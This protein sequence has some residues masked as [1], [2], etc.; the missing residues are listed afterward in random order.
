MAAGFPN[1]HRGSS[2]G[3]GG[4]GGVAQ[5]RKPIS[6]RGLST[7]KVRSAQ[8]HWYIDEPFMYSVNGTKYYVHQNHLFSAMAQTLGTGEI[9]WRCSYDAFG[10]RNGDHAGNMARGWKGM[11][12]DL[13]TGLTYAR[14][15]Y[16]NSKNGLFIN[17]FPYSSAS[18]HFLSNY[19]TIVM[20]TSWKS[21]FWGSVFSSPYP[22]RRYSLYDAFVGDPANSLEPFSLVSGPTVTAYSGINDP[23]NSVAESFAM[24]G[25]W[26]EG[27]TQSALGTGL[28]HLPFDN[29][30]FPFLF[31]S[32][33][34]LDLEASYSGNMK[35]GQFCCKDKPTK[36]RVLM[37]AP[38]TDTK[39]NYSKKCCD[40][41]F[42]VIWSPDDPVFNQ[43]PWPFNWDLE[44]QSYWE[45]WGETYTSDNSGMPSGFGRHAFDSFGGNPRITGKL[46]SGYGKQ[47]SSTR[48]HSGVVPNPSDLVRDWQGDQS[49]SNIYVCHS[50]GCNRLMA[51]LNRAC[52]SK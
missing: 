47:R 45:Q 23:G 21:L 35:D 25:I 50:Q 4:R 2:A 1:S 52:S 11:A 7:V 5:A 17:R 12:L 15:R 34:R 16:Y 13:E 9:S 41:S 20:P 10:T 22:Q 32:E 43:G 27:D 3:P 31:F 48:I 46:T 37:V 29:V 44:S 51:D 42:T 49:L 40:I 36:I 33:S 26:T 6:H 38:K 19:S 8:G 14:S 18:G 39:P 24:D 28:G 30:I